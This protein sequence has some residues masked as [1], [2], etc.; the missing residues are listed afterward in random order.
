MP[1]R[2]WR[3]RVE[4]ML[5][6]IHKIERYTTGMT[7]ETFFAKPQTIEAVAYNFIIGEAARHIPPEIEARY[8]EVPWLQMRDLRNF[9]AHEYPKVKPEATVLKVKSL[10]LVGTD[11]ASACQEVWLRSIAFKITRSLRMHAT[12]AT[13]LALPW[14][15]SRS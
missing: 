15:S 9:L 6:A 13:F 11:G 5:E 10:G 1:P 2:Q 14:A 8:P 3:L 4:D 7:P 12:S